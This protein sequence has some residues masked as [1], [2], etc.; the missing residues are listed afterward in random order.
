MTSG[1][2]SAGHRKDLFSKQHLVW[3]KT[4]KCN[5]GLSEFYFSL[6]LV[7]DLTFSFLPLSPRKWNSFDRQI[8]L[9]SAY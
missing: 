7:S 2:V 1:I 3:F 6:V 8:L 5:C 9:R 4:E